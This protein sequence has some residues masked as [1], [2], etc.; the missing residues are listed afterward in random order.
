M[1]IAAFKSSSRR[2]NL[3]ASPPSSTRDDAPKKAPIR[4]SRSVS[5]L[6]RSSFDISTEFINK[7]DNPL[8]CSSTTSSPRDDDEVESAKTRGRSVMRDGE[9]SSSKGAVMTGRKETGR[10]MSRVD[11]GRRNRSAS[12][13]PVSRR[14]YSTSEDCSVR[15]SKD[16]NNL[17][18]VGSNRKGGLFRSND[19]MMDQKMKNLQTWSNQHSASVASD[20][21]AK[22]LSRLQ[23][24]NCEDA[25]LTASSVY[26]SEEKTIKAVCEQMKSIQADPLEASD[27]YETVRSEV[28]RAIFE[29]QN[30][31]ESAIRRSNA[32]AIA[33]TNVA[34]IPPDLV[35]PGAVELVL[36]IRREYS[37]KLEESQE[38]ARKLRA[39]L[40]VEEH[41]GQELDRIL[42]E[43]LPYPKTPNVQKSRPQRKTSIERR[44]VSKR[45]QEDA[46]AYFDECISLSTF[47]S[48]DFSSQE[49][50]PP[51]LV[52]PPTSFGGHLPEVSSSASI[53]KKSMNSILQPDLSINSMESIK[54][55]AS[56]TT[57]STGS[58][59]KFQF[60]FTQ[61]PSETSS[62]IHYD[63]QQY[64]KNFDKSVVKLSNRSSS[65][66]CDID[67]YS[68]S[69]SAENLLIDSVLMKNRIESGSLLLCSGGNN[70]W[71]SKF[72]GVGI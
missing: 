51:N 3:A 44:K 15:K 28:R 1:A 8:F 7:R 46:M 36:D 58:G 64:I 19:G 48:S 12:Q 66:Y 50:P 25:V 34:D 57:S 60:S 54:D 10:S 38:R 26:G 39:D 35:N 49:D 27:I 70:L 40:A 31:L 17:K 2:G 65:N 42:K 59:C 23:S 18:L 68:Y 61:K 55:Q 37:K 63:I 53:S 67:K 11:T 41:R 21:S 20:R 24:R 16:G 71:C 32:T 45:L 52:G 62:E 56:P 29:I 4:R 33:V 47:D 69:S 13:V 30:D 22:T 5:A 72:C 6:S 14:L 9:V 43:V